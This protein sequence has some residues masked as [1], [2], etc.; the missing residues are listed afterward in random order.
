MENVAHE[1]NE[2]ALIGNILGDA[3]VMARLMMAER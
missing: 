2:F 3:T 1:P